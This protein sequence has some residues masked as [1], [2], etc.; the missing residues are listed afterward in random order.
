LGEDGKAVGPVFTSQ[1]V[2]DRKADS[3]AQSRN[4]QAKRLLAE[5]DNYQ[6]KIDNGLAQLERMEAFGQEG[7][8]PYQKASA[9]IQAKNRDFKAKQDKL[10]ADANT[11]SQPLTVA[12]KGEKPVTRE[13]FT[14]FEGGQPVATFPT[15]QAAEEAALTRLDDETLQKVA[16]L[17]RFQKGLM[18]KRLAAMAKKEMDLRAGREPK[19]I[20]IKIT[21]TREEAEARLAEAGIFVGEFQQKA[22][23]L[24]K[25]LRPIM[26]KLGLKDLRLNIEKA[27]T[28]PMGEAD[29]YYAR[30]LIAISM[31]A[32]NPIRTLRHEGIHALKELGAFT[33]DQW[34]VLT[35]KAKSEWIDKYDIRNRYRSLNEEEMIEEAISD[36]FSDFD[37]TKPPS[38]LIGALFRKIKQF[39]E[40]L[41]NGIRGL[42]FQTADDVFTRVEEGG[43]KPISAET[44]EAAPR[45][46][47][48]ILSDEE[49]QQIIENST[50]DVTSEFVA[51][52]LINE[53]NRWAQA[54]SSLPANVQNK[55]DA[56]YVSSR[57]AGKTA[58]DPGYWDKGAR[59]AETRTFKAARQALADYFGRDLS[60]QELTLYMN[61]WRGDVDQIFGRE[62]SLDRTRYAMRVSEPESPLAQ[63]VSPAEAEAR[64][65]RRLGRAK[66]IGAPS[67]DRMTFGRGREKLIVGKITP[68]DWKERVQ[69][70]MSVP[71]IEDARNWYQQLNDFFTPVFGDRASEYSLAWL[72]SQQRASPTKGFTDVLRASDIA[73]NKLRI[74]KAGL[75]E[76]SLVAALRGEVPEGGIGAKLLDFVD[77]ELGKSVR[78]VMGGKKEGRQPAAIDVW[79]QRDIGFIDDTVKEFVA[80]KFGKEAADMLDVDTARFGEPQYEYGVDFYND[81]AEYLNRQKYMGGGWTAREVQAVGWVN[82]QKFMG[83]KPEFVRDI[84]NGNTRRVSIGLAPGK[85][86][87]MTG[88]LMGK[89]IPVKDAQNIIND[90]AKISNIKV[91]QSIDG[92]GA[93]LT[94]VEGSIQV[95]AV[96]SPESVD[97]FMD[98]IGY[99]FQQTEVINTRPL[100]SGKNSAID[101]LSPSLNSQS[102]AIQFFTEYLK[103]MPKVEVTNEKRVYEEK[104]GKIVE[105]IIKTTSMAP[106]APG[107]QQVKVDGVPG[108]RLVNFGGKWNKKQLEALGKAADVAEAA[109]GIKNARFVDMNVQFTSTANDWV[110]YPDGDQYVEALRNRGRLQEAQLL[111]D[112][113]PPTRFDLAGDGTINWRPRL[114]FRPDESIDRSGLGS[115]ISIREQQ[116]NAQSYDAVHYGKQRVNTLAGSMYGTGIKGAEAQRVFASPDPRVRQRAYFYIP[117]PNGRMPRPEAGLGSE[118]H[119]Q[120]LNNLLGPGD[121]MQ[122]FVDATRAPDGRMDANA[123]ESAVIDAG[124]DGYAVPDMG[125]AVVLGAD[126]PVIPR[127]GGENTVQIGDRKYALR[128]TD[129]PEFREWFGESKIAT[130]RG[131]PKRMYHGTARDFTKFKPKQAN[132]I[133]LTDDPRFAEGFSDMSEDY[134]VNEFMDNATPE[135]SLKIIEKAIA[136]GFKDKYIL[137]SAATTLRGMSLKEAVRTAGVGDYIRSLIKE[138]LPSGQNIMPLY[139]RAENPF[140]YDNRDDVKRL[141]NEIKDLE[142]INSL[143]Q[144][145]DLDS[146]SELEGFLRGGEW[147]II[148]EPE[149]QRIIK[150]LGFDSFY[151]N[152]GDRKNLAVYSPNQVKSAIGNFGTFSRTDKDIRYALALGNIEPSTALVPDAGGN[153]DGILG[154]MPDRFGGKPIRMLIGTHNDLVPEL[155]NERMRRPLSYGA[156]HILNRVLSDP[157]R[158]PG[159]AEELLEKIVK[160]AQTTAQK[161][162]QIFKEGNMFII[163]DGRNSLIVS[164]EDDAMSIVTMYVQNQPERRY[165]NAVFSGRAPSVPQE[166]VKPI[167]GMNVVAG[168]GRVQIKPSEV[169]VIKPSKVLEVSPATEITPTKAGKIS[170]KKPVNKYS[171]ALPKESVDD[172]FATTDRLKEPEG[173]QIIRENWIGGVAGIGDRDSAY[174]LKRVYGGPEYVQSVQDLVR[175]NFGDS[176]KGYRLMS[177]DELGELESGA[178]GTQL[179]S[180]TLDPMVGLRFSSLPMYARR[181]KGELVVVEM[182]LTPEHVQMIGHLPEKEL[183]IDYGVG[184]NTDE[185]NAYASP[186]K[187][188]SKKF[189][190][191]DTIDPAIA[192]SI[193][194][195][196]TK[197]E[198]KGFVQRM[199]E[200]ISPTA[201]QRFR[202]GMI[203]KY[204]SIELLSQDVAKQF[205][206]KELLA[207][208]SAIAAALFS[209]RAAG[210]AASSF[211]NGVPIYQKGFTS[212]SNLNNTVKGLIPI[213]Q[214]FAQY[215][216][217]YVF[218]AFQF[219]AAT[220]R[221]KRLTAEG[222]EKL[223]TPAEI[224]QGALLEQQYPEFKQVFDEYQKYNKGLVD[225]MKDTGVLSEEEAKIWTQN[226]DYIP[227]YRQME[228]EE[229]AGP[230]VFSPIAGVSKP[231][232]L[233]GGEA[234]LADF[235][236]TVVRNSRAA[237]EAGMKNV[238]AQKVVR[239]IMRLNQGEFVPAPLARGSDIVTVKENGKT[240]HYR[241]DDPLLVEALKGLNLPQLPFLEILSKPA[242]VLRNLV[243]KDPGFM[244]A[245][246]MRD[247]LQAWVTTGTNIIPIVDTFKQYGQVLAGMSPEAQALANAGLFAGYDFGGDVKSTAREVESELRKRAGQRTAFE[248]ATLPLSKMWELLDKGSTASDVATRAEVYKRTLAETGNEAEAL[249]Q[250]MEVLNFSRKGN[251][252]LIRVLTATIPFMNARIQGLDV[253]Y[254]A[255]FGKMATRTKERQQKAFITRG[256]TL[257]ALSSMYWMLASDTEEYKTAEPETRDNN[258]IIGSVRIPIPFEIGTIFKVFPE[259]IYEYF[260]GEDTS[261]DLKESIVRN[262]TSTLAFNPIPQAVLPI[263]E[264]VA[265]Y[266]FFTGQPIVGKGLEDVSK[267]FQA[268]PGT[269]L[270]AQ[271]VGQATGQSPIMIDNLIRGYTGTIGTYAVMA[272]DSIMRGEGDPTKATMRAE[273]LPVIKRFFA[274]PESTGTVTAYYDLKNR[275]DE[276][277]RTVNFLERTGGVK[278]LQEYLQDKGAKLL[279]IKPYVQQLDKEMTTLREM[280][281]AIQFSKIDPDQKREVLDN[282]RRAEV[283]LT[284]RIQYIKKSID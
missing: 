58:Q 32:P 182:D 135:Q 137:P 142:D 145:V 16:S 155:D 80:K 2:A 160:T 265:N 243:T 73:E 89:E 191:R 18:P 7:T 45:Y 257:F 237:I 19:G 98:M 274:S 258:W 218:Q 63:Y 238:A 74:K 215:G 246:L 210:V 207:D 217:P 252:A 106:I 34:R 196:T 124:Y 138:Q 147:G 225:F 136:K 189:S 195:T 4:T 269:S 66:D 87:V 84:V 90:L 233:K 10:R 8:V 255:G 120:R 244:L 112:Q 101:I 72:L 172:F 180:F 236:E 30:R 249:Y 21:G 219:Y 36:A 241:V 261:R 280:R 92:I 67:N 61:D 169:K 272:L 81:V 157:S 104:D 192:Q 108:I 70:T 57:K 149:I 209:D 52:N 60:P 129:T 118:V 281:R 35:N 139:V 144:F 133:F 188:E 83:V 232:K 78:T 110:K 130:L 71:E 69:N 105:R 103:A 31:T 271:E 94:Y 247:S 115:G 123:F 28:S 48:P 235:M 185:I 43:L 29:G 46:S 162:N 159:G 68:Q 9:N 132:A 251:S 198:E 11:L 202:Q 116:P 156:N 276:A 212:V 76:K 282:I 150:K 190:L 62:P 49:S 171:L 224:Q 254:R 131:E 141:M 184:Y 3:Y 126:V 161:Y 27:I 158:I 100:A 77:S 175:E 5:A 51:N 178:M 114:A 44:V 273:Q 55:L 88:R 14:I 53:Y 187:P 151:V 239:D 270:L 200:A 56:Y 146:L 213:L 278:D 284:S 50:G 164:P 20:G 107:F 266:S 121:E 95:D 183:V 59:A 268:T 253:L 140:D 228:G 127:E 223:F 91:T 23:E 17:G 24:S 174:D 263:V 214:P 170:I 277:T 250:A 227:F 240:K 173:V 166:F 64:L 165:G 54:F 231:K 205:G 234:P 256:L 102:K 206:S 6:K 25:K 176:F 204:E 143:L 33:T 65:R 97:S 194:R 75:N 193:D 208:T 222:R 122:S 167:R 40:L 279:S 275:V 259:R 113:F 220:K 22:A 82:M 226:W 38:G 93:Y 119:I 47:I 216:D 99:V 1:D 79:A 117:Y 86:S 203:N 13:G 179:A 12:P 39:M 153:P 186:Y 26:D 264:N 229:I 260:F 134:M 37:Q 15:Q 177:R 211:L 148:E 42:G 96:G 262:L 181:P 267:P 201:F 221:G 125:M 152:E 109:T 85:G 128:Q 283:A 242:E 111:R 248:T 163:Y 41:G 230:R 199:A 245:N 154:F 197:R 168:E